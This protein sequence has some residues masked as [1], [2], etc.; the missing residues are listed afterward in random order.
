ML[1]VISCLLPQVGWWSISTWFCVFLTPKFC[2]QR[3]FLCMMVTNCTGERSFSIKDALRLEIHNPTA[4]AHCII[5]FDY[6]EKFAESNWVWDHNA[7]F[8]CSTVVLTHCYLTFS[9]EL[10]RQQRSRLC[11]VFRVYAVTQMAHRSETLEGR[12]GGEHSSLRAERGK[13][14]PVRFTCVYVRSRRNTVINEDKT[15]RS[16]LYA[17]TIFHSSGAYFSRTFSD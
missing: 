8:W 12:G 1:T 14:S 9:Y 7:G 13:A 3:I 11:I 4:K 15:W 6:K 5:A 17:P 16:W 10:G 2:I